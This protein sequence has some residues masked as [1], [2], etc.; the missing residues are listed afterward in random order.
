MGQKNHSALS[1]NS[2]V[3]DVSADSSFRAS[4]NFIEGKGLTQQEDL[5]HR[6]YRQSHLSMNND[7][8]NCPFVSILYA[9]TTHLSKFWH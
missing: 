5:S 7:I 9:G 3:N 6:H 8:L 4:F 1:L 2:I